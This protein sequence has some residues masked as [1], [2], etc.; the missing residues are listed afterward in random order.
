MAVKYF[1][2]TFL[3][4]IGG[5]FS[6]LSLSASTHQDDENTTEIMA[7]LLPIITFILNDDVGGTT[8]FI[9]GDSTVHRHNINCDTCEVTEGWGDE[10]HQYVKNGVTVSNRARAGASAETYR[11]VNTYYGADR[12]WQDTYERMLQTAGKKYLLIQFGSSNE[13]RFYDVRY[14]RLDD[15]GQIIDYN[16]DGTGNVDD[17]AARQLLIEHDFKEAV[18]FYID[19]ARGELNAVPILLSPPNS[20]Q[21]TSTRGPYPGYVE[22]LAYE[23]GV[24]YLNLHQMSL[25]EY[26]R[27]THDELIE[28]FGLH[29]EDG[30]VD[31]TH[32]NVQGAIIVGGWVK[33]LI[34]TNNK[35]ASLCQVFDS[36]RYFTF[37]FA[38][39]DKTVESGTSV[40][41]NATPYAYGLDTFTYRW[42]ENGQLLSSEKSFSKSDFSEGIHHIT[43]TITDSQGNRADDSVEITVENNLQEATVY[44]DAEDGNTEGWALYGTTDGA[45]ITNV[46]DD[47]RQ[48]RVI[49]LDGENGLDNGFSFT[50]LNDSDN[51]VVSWALKYSEDF[52]FFVK[53]QT[54]NSDHDP[55]YMTYQPDATPPTDEEVSGKKYLHIGLGAIARSGEWIDIERNID[56]DL[57]TR[58]PDENV[59]MIYGIYIRGSGRI[60]DI[61]FKHSGGIYPAQ[62]P[63]FYQE[64]A[65]VPRPEPRESYKEPVFGTKVTR[66][67]DRA[68]QT[69]NTHPYPKQGSAWNSDATIIRMQYRLYDAVTFEEL[70]VTAGLDASHAYAKVGSP[71]HGS[72][73]IRWSK[74]DP[75]VMYVLDSHQR[76]KR[77][78]INDERTDTVEEAPLIDLSVLGYSNITTGNN[79]GNLDYRDS[80]IVFAAEKENNESVF[81]LLYQVGQNALTW[82]RELP[83]GLW[84]D[85]WDDPD[86]FDWISVDPS[87]HYLLINAEQKMWL[88][89]M[90]LSHEVQ[91]ADVG[92]HG[93]IGID[94]N[95][96][97][98]YVQFISGG[99][100]I[101]SY[102]LRTHQSLDLLPSNYGGGHI[103]CRNY[104]RPGWC[105]VNTSQEGYK[106]IFAIKLD[107]HI[108]GTVERFVQSHVTDE[109]HGQT[110]VNVSP[111][112]TK[113]LFGSDFANTDNALDTYQATIRW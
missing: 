37:A 76:F 24:A 83:R 50:N 1:M 68:N 103:S 70:P 88:Y 96:D 78:I 41:F 38:G 15:N 39:D 102:N 71:A 92:E 54:S 58:F 12:Y 69:A 3:L 64:S 101:R 112:G 20:K 65:S 43:L 51:T 95:G 10:L 63:F 100:A 111:D 21:S 44:E 84:K 113:V 67:T 28:L 77:V 81:G 5:L 85:A 53:V 82:E 93:D 62:S 90:N 97:P 99:T 79:E 57:H 22:T 109:K 29:R 40:T 108:S 17:E 94:V 23:K 6:P 74:T 48:S 66:I 49:V 80:Y 30:S 72:A 7:K 45:S 11:E 105:Y 91:L 25:D 59:T 27:Y 4:F 42:E 52:R 86:G 55:L 31:N 104:K 26:S 34:C 13:Q 19:K 18:A 98:T 46:Y 110:Q 9:I 73:D 60:D 107:D 61:V 2:I 32:Y 75:N 16:H 14:P 36:Q 33:E 47:V 87:A 35:T 89:D 106:E 56:A 8:I